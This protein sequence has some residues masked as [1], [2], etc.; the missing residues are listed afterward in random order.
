MDKAIGSPSPYNTIVFSETVIPLPVLSAY[1]MI[2]EH[3]S[4]IFVSKYALMH[5]SKDKQNKSCALD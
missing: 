3:H 5:L 1:S 4:V 2:K